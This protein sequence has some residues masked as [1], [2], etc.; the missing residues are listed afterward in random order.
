[1]RSVGHSKTQIFC[2]HKLHI[3]L[4]GDSLIELAIISATKGVIWPALKLIFHTFVGPSSASTLLSGH[5][6][7]AR[8]TDMCGLSHFFVRKSRRTSGHQQHGPR[9][10]ES[11]STA[12]CQ[13]TMPPTYE[14]ITQ[15]KV[16]LLL[17]LS[18]SLS[19]SLSLYLSPS[20]CFSVSIYISISIYICIYLSLYRS[21]APKG[22]EHL[23]LSMIKTSGSE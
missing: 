14:F 8:I 12:C 22:N 23:R 18:L 4:V 1:M 2:I 20:L 15:L 9:V 19:F 6:S 21:H 16:Q 3:H 17:S 5:T 13:T 11:V 7:K 10:T